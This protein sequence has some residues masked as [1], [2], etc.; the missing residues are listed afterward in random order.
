[1]QLPSILLTQVQRMTS[2]AFP[3]RRVLQ[4]AELSGGLINTN[5]KIDFDDGAPVVL[6]IY[7]DGAVARRKELAIYRL[8]SERVPV[9][10]VLFS[11]TDVID[12]LPAFSFVQ[13]VEG[14]T[15]QQLKRTMN[16]SAIA[17]AAYSV[18]ATLAVVSSF[19][20]NHPG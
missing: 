15:F 1:M 17:E 4:F 13:Y 20:F 5:I 6:R 11:S 2:I 9:P 8:I 3:G 7:R 18:G 12:N 16:R 10:S 19:Q 14:F